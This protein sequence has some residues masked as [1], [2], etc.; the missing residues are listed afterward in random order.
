[1]TITDK[2]YSLLPDGS[3]FKFWDNET[4]FTKTYYV[5]N[6]LEMLERGEDLPMQ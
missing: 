5:S 2:K 6:A 3:Q 1:M 4:E